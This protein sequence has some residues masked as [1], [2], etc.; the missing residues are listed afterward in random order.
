ML[1][2]VHTAWYILAWK[3]IRRR[4]LIHIFLWGAK[5]NVNRATPPPSPQ[6]FCPKNPPAFF[7]LAFPLWKINFTYSKL[8][9]QGTRFLTEIARFLAFFLVLLGSVFSFFRRL[10]YCGVNRV[11]SFFLINSN[12]IFWNRRFNIFKSL[13]KQCCGSRMIYSGSSFN[14]SEFRIQPIPVLVIIFVKKKKP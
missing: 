1:F 14:F 9:D 4:Q 3:E 10:L 12:K 8:R 2:F 5:F 13:I 11:I 7:G 6:N